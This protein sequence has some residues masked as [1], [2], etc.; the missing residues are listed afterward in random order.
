M[1]TSIKHC[2]VI[3]LAVLWTATGM[4]AQT[5]DT[6][7]CKDRVILN[8]GSVFTGYLREYVPNKRL[9]LETCAGLMLHF[10]PNRVKRILQGCGEDIPDIKLKPTYA[11]PEK[12]WYHHTRAAIL[13]G[14]NYGGDAIPGLS[15]YHASGWQFNRLLGAGIGLGMETY[16]MESGSEPVTYPLFLEVRSYWMKRRVSP[17]GALSLGYAWAGKVPNNWNQTVDYDGGLFAKFQVGYRMGN[18]FTL[19]GGISV[20]HKTRHWGNVDSFFGTDR[21]LNKRLELGFGLLL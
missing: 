7:S 17:Y 13:A 14:N 16:D 3:L 12:G 21:I 5:A 10:H 18:H 6:A 8:N 19:H 20:Q 15:L 4:R 1:T 11:F 2:C 9:V